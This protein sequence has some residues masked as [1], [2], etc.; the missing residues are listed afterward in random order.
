M[1]SDCLRVGHLNVYHI[2][3]FFPDLN[4][5]FES[6]QLFHLFGLSET[7]LKNYIPSEGLFLPHY[8]LIRKDATRSQHTGLVVYIHSSISKIV[9]RRPD[10][11]SEAVESVWLE[12][13]TRKSSI[14]VGYIYRNPAST[15]D[16]YDQF[17]TMMDKVQGCNLN[18]VLLGDFNI[19]MQKSNPAWDSTV[20]LFGLNQMIMSPTRI[21]PHFSTLIDHIYTN[22]T[23]IVSNILVPATGISDHFPVCCTLSVKTVKPVLNVHSS[24]VYRCFKQFDE[25]AFLMDLHVIPFENV[26][27]FSD[28]NVALSHW[29]DLFLDVIN[30]H[31]SLKKRRRKEEEKKRLKHQTLP[32]WLNTDIKQAMLLRDKCRK[33]KK[34]VEYKQQRNRVNYLEREAKNIYFFN[35]LAGNKAD[36]S[37]I[38]PISVFE[39]GISISKLDNTKSTGCD[40]IKVKLL[41]IALPDI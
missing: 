34:F 17:V 30:K 16:W 1:S 36:I 26:Y 22:D 10:L 2:Q 40:G 7:R 19:D 3:N 20:S 6:H 33:Q 27:N 39:Q 41:K 9:R 11:E 14:L 31:A 18:V 37:S 4:V 38:P 12:I 25:R 21:T 23:S 29:I 15:F 8:S 28:P 35:D 5:F 13:Q 32:P 24:I